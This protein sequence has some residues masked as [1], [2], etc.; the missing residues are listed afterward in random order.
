[1]SVHCDITLRRVSSGS[2][3]IRARKDDANLGDPDC[4]DPFDIDR[5]EC[6]RGKQSCGVGERIQ[7]NCRNRFAGTLD[8]FIWC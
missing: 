2:S 5:V 3:V 4:D 8:F 6:M 1:M 7:N